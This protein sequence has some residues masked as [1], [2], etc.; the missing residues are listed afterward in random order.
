MDLVHMRRLRRNWAKCS[1]VGSGAGSL[2]RDGLGW[3]WHQ[4]LHDV[5]QEVWCK[6]GVSDSHRDALVSEG[7][8]NRPQPYACHRKPRGERVTE[9][10]P[11]EIRE[12]SLADRLFKPISRP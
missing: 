12:I 8:L 6:V 11:V 3:S 7:V 2:R 1:G 5:E 10:V 4:P 9:V